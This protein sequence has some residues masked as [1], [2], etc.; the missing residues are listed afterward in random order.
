MKTPQLTVC[1]V[2]VL[3]LSCN[4]VDAHE[5][6]PLRSGPTDRLGEVN[7][8]ISCSRPAQQ[9]FNQAVAMLHSFFYTEAG[10][11]FVKVTELDPACAMGYWGIAMSS[12]YPLW[13]PPTKESLTQGSTA[14]DKARGIQSSTQREQMYI[15]AIGAFYRD[16]ES[17]DHKSRAMAYEKAMQQLYQRYPEDSEAGAFYALALQ[18]TA[19]PNDKTYANQLASAAILEP[20]FAEQPNHPGVAHYLIHAY[21]YPEL[22]PRALTAA[23]RYGRIAPAMPHALH[24]PS[25][26]FIAL[27][28]WQESIQSNLGAKAAAEMAGW[29][30]EELH[31]MDYLVYAYLQ[32]AQLQRAG[33]VLGEFKAATVNDKAH[34]LATDYSL[35]A[36]PA[37]F[38]VEQRRWSDAA[39]LEPRPSRFAVTQATT[40]FARALGAA[41]TGA[42]EDGTKDMQQIATLRDALLQAKQEYWAKQLD[43]QRMTADAWLTWAQGNGEAALALMRAAADLEDSTYK[44]PIA[45]AQLL[46][47][48]ELLGD[49]LLAVGKPDQALVEYETSLRVAPNRFNGLYGA[50]RAAELAGNREKATAYYAQLLTICQQADTQRAE[51]EHARLYLAGS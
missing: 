47:A 44:H 30:Q 46:P 33:S 50:A 25:H 29:I 19:N 9:Q 42:I 4:H 2:L 27:G 41:H 31:S 35:A 7:F 18:A 49:M 23:R 32:G 20:L 48:R 12:W 5:D 10:K 22:A 28:L 38:A 26:T 1:F 21:D 43:V 11:S 37:R 36:A 24:M 8:P 40:Y 17:V 51:V 6:E 39:A 3:L 13:Y 16:F 45:P 14:V 34:T 15:A